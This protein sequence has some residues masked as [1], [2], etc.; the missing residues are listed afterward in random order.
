MER[1]GEEGWGR[2]VPE[3]SSSFLKVQLRCHFFY[4]LLSR[5]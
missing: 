1:K 4:E 2:F 3:N 5:L